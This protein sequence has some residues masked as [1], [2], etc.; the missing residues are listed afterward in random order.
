MCVDDSKG[1]AQIISGLRIQV[2]VHL[3]GLFFS[4]QKMMHN[5]TGGLGVYP[6]SSSQKE[7][8]LL[9]SFES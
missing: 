2:T 8:G 9:E 4:K 6:Q 3:P 5:F 1:A 7:S